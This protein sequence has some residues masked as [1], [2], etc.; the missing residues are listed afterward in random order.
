MLPGYDDGGYDAAGDGAPEPIAAPARG[1]HVQGR[2]A[3]GV[4]GVEDLEEVEFA[5][6]GCPA[7]EGEGG[8][9][10]C[11]SSFWPQG[12]GGIGEVSE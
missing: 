3:A 5:A 8:M 6:A 7:V 1:R 4:A 11:V 9:L 12:A 2:F 10:A